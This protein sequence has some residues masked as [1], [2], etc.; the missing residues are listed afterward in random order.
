MYLGRNHYKDHLRDINKEYTKD[1]IITVYNMPVADFYV[2]P[3]EIF[4]PEQRLQ[5]YDNSTWAYT[6][7]WEFG[8]DSSSTLKNPVHYYSD[9][10]SYSVTLHVWSEHNCYD[11]ITQRNLVTVLQSG[12]VEFPTAFTPS[13]TGP[14]DGLYDENDYTN[15]VFH[16]L[17]KGPREDFRDPKE[18]T[19]S[20]RPLARVVLR[21]EGPSLW[22]SVI[23][24]LHVT[25][26]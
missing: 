15:D 5:C 12:K 14:G 16:P 24:H 3:E 8:D 11:K 22:S 19:S 18:R 10:G 4:I 23:F 25:C 1:T 26:C 17:V 20:S 7:L 6:Y 2:A 9:T 13:S 21:R